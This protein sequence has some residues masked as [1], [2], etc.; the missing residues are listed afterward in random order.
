MRSNKGHLD[1]VAR[2]RVVRKW[3]KKLLARLEEVVH[4]KPNEA[5][6]R[7]AVE[8]LLD[9]FCREARVPPMEH[10]EFSFASGKADAVFSRFVIEYK[11]PGVLSSNWN[12]ITRSAV[13]QVKGYVRDKATK[14]GSKR[15]AG[16]VFD[17]CYI[18]LVRFRGG[19]FTTQGPLAVNQH[20][21]ATFL[22][23]LAGLS[24]GMAL[25]PENL[26]ADFAVEQPHTQNTLAAFYSALDTALKGENRIVSKL[27]EQWRLFF[28]ESIDYS[29]AF[30][31]RK[32]EPLKKW[33]AKAG[34]DIKS[35]ED[36]ERFFFV[37]HT[38][39][40]LL[41]KLLAWL[42]LSR[43]IGG[44][45]G[46]PSFTRLVS[47]ESEALRTKLKEME[48]GG[49][50]KAY[51]VS[52]L[53]EGDFF[54]WYLFAWNE[55]MESG[56]RS[57]LEHLNRYDPTTL[58]IVPDETRDLFKKLY[59]Y[60]LP[61][62]VRHNLG[63]Y[64]TPDWLAQRLLNQVDNK[65]FT[66]DPSRDEK[67]MTRKL[68]NTRFLDPACGSGTFLVLTI[69]RMR[70]MADSLPIK[71]SDLLDAILSNVVGIDL[72][73][74]AVLTAR[75][76]YVLNISPLLEHAKGEVAIPVYLADSVR[77]PA[78]GEGLFGAGVYQFPTAVGKF[79]VPAVLCK[80]GRFD[81][82][83]G[84]LEDSVRSEMS[85]ENFTDRVTSELGLRSDWDHK[86]ASVLAKLYGS[87]LDLHKQGMN[88]LWARLLRNNFAPLTIG[89][90]DYIVGNPP[91]VLWDNLPDA[92]RDSIKPLWV[93][94]GL[95]P[96]SGLD[97]ILG[98]GKKD[99][100]M[101]MT[102]TTCDALLKMNGRLGFVISQSVFKTAGSGQG[103]RRFAIP[104]EGQRDVPLKA[105]YAD[106]MVDLNPFEGASNRTAVLVIEKGRAT[107]YPVPYTLWRRVRGQRFTPDS[108][109]EDTIRATRRLNF[110]AEPVD[111]TDPTS[112][113]LTTRRG[114][115][116]ATRRLLG[117]SQYT[118]HAGA[119]SGGTN[120]V[121]WLCEVSRRTGGLVVVTNITEGAKIEVDQTTL[122][123]EPDLLY[124]L[125]RPRDLKKW[126]ASTSASIIMA[127]DPTK[128]R[129]WDV[130][131]MQKRWPETYSYLKRFEKLLRQ[132]AAYK[133]YYTPGRDPFYSMFDIGP[134]TFADWKVVWT[135][136]GSIQAA[137]VGKERKKAVVPQET[138]SLVACGTAAEAHY[139]AA[140][141]NS[142]PFQ[143]AAVSYS[144]AGGKS[145]GSPHVLKNIR[146]PR[147][148]PKDRAHKQL[149]ELSAQAHKVAK[150]GEQAKLEQIEAEVDEQAAELWGLSAVELREIQRSLEE[151]TERS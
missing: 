20:S 83:C 74:L 39:F 41:V 106:D 26:C 58:A 148:N 51:G 149:A 90:F 50:F 81:R 111:A 57:L 100:S 105:V 30:G 66:S 117:N 116:K 132:R 70:D 133:R 129:G 5:D 126:H 136:I 109:L 35:S 4:K 78:E 73:P 27:F 103:F 72:N 130:S 9:Q 55:D 82:F 112:A 98:K 15:L 95:F 87:L 99:I 141:V 61:R 64:Y 145:M 17:G 2:D 93:K 37:L 124:P 77:T 127:Q 3:A 63:E 6:F 45:L 88:G 42:A 65:Y 137:V 144:Q 53:L 56:V 147:Y 62:Q 60:L 146:I 34:I 10:A 71:Q 44:K 36:A 46:G 19:K 114:A 118:A 102:Y 12:L 91:W 131:E 52:N 29:S 18:I 1:P 49:I 143:F 94:Y 123:I 150:T 80:P 138:I 13:D 97:T 7:R 33:V 119:Y 151:L 101:L 47:A 11:R 122:P 21:L 135:R 121:F 92:Y 120:A 86:D 115:L 85:A 89:Q 40:A 59:H 140:T 125:L 76:N 134:Y 32:L 84:L 23:W 107:K 69:A 43:H 75:V 38:Y 48:D 139:L 113:W 25:T 108:S 54:S 128:R 96:H 14:D 31:G 22:S 24:T 67:G 28:S 16:V 110:V 8:P 68:L 79:E 104:V 142:T